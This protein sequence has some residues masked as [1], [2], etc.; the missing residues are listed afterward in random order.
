MIRK[1]KISSLRTLALVLVATGA[2][3]TSVPRAQ[4]SSP[5]PTFITTILFHQ[6]SGDYFSV[7]SYVYDQ[8]TGKLISGGGQVQYSICQTG[9]YCRTMCITSQI[10]AN[11]EATCNFAVNEPSGEYTVVASYSGSTDYLPSSKNETVV[12][13]Y[14]GITILN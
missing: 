11:G 3:I 10:G 8:S 13:T 4:A 5:S 6:I 9:T 2:L 7:T 14:S 12:I 1:A